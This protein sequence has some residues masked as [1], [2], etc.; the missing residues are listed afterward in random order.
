MVSQFW[1]PVTSKS[2]LDSNDQAFME[3]PLDESFQLLV[4]CTRIRSTTIHTRTS[5]WYI[6]TNLRLIIRI[7]PM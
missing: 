1:E 3:I 7:R 2:E 6:L 5:N 4:I